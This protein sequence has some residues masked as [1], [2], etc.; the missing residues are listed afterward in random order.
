MADKENNGQVHKEGR[1]YNDPWLQSLVGKSITVVER[2]NTI[3][4]GTL[5]DYGRY[6]LRV[7][8][9]KIQGKRSV[10]VPWVIIE[11]AVVAHQHPTPEVVE[12]SQELHRSI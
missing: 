2:N 1:K 5:I 9:V 12:E 11:R 7:E 6:R 3:L 4:T 10:N 8:G